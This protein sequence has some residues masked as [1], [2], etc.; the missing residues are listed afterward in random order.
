MRPHVL[1][2]KEF[3]ATRRGQNARR[4][5]RHAI[6]AMWP[7]LAGEALLGLGF[8][9]PCLGIYREEAE[10]VVA[11]MPASQGVIA[12]PREANRLVAVA[13]ESE[14]PLADNS[15]DRILLLHALELSEELHPMMDEV[16]RV[17]RPHGR[18]LAVVPNRRGLWA[19]M[20]RT[21][22][23]HGHPFTGG[24]LT[25]LLRDHGFVPLRQKMTLYVP[26]SRSRLVLRT[27]GLWLKLGQRLAR[28][29]G[30][31]LLIEAE[32]EIYA[33]RPVGRRARRRTGVRMRASAV[34][35]S[36]RNA[37]TPGGCMDIN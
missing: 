25:R 14:L 37:R 2:L 18:L 9:T 21:P 31:V 10:R 34:P 16:W 13:E 30:G 23:G 11:L 26:P 22:F 17:L 33:A 19:R 29:F 27:S 1:E 6:R 20:E 28:P 35:A 4:V 8:A 15:M 5:I 7:T 3:Y 32:K 24:Q 36:A 12:W